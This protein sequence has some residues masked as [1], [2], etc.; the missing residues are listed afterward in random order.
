MIRSIGELVD[1]LMSQ[2]S[3]NPDSLDGNDR[4]MLNVA[5]RWTGIKQ[6]AWDASNQLLLIESED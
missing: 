4:V 3:D 5:G 6:I 1:E 2:L